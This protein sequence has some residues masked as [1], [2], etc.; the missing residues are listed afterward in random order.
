MLEKSFNIE[1]ISKFIAVFLYSVLIAF[2]ILILQT[3]YFAIFVVVFAPFAFIFLLNKPVTLLSILILIMP[4]SATSLFDMQIMGVPGLKLINILFVMTFFSFIHA[5]RPVDV[6]LN[7]KLFIIGTIALLLIAVIRSVPHIPLFNIIWSEHYSINRYFQSFLLKPIIYLSPFIYLSLFISDRRILRKILRIYIVSMVLLSTFLLG[8]YIF[9]APDKANFESVRESLSVAMHLHGNNLATIYT[10]SFPIF[11]SVFFIRKSILS[12]TGLILVVITIGILYSRTAYFLIVL[13]T[14]L[15]LLISKRPKFI[16]F[17][18]FIGI[19]LSVF[20]PHSI[21][22]RA[23]TGLQSKDR[24]EISAGRIDGIWIPLMQEI[25][26]SPKNVLI[27]RGRHAI[28]FS[29][30]HNSG[31][32]YR[33]GHAHNMYL[34]IL[35]DT[36]LIGLMFFLG[37][38]LFYLRKY[39]IH[40]KKLD[41]LIEDREMLY[42]VIVSIICFLIAGMTGRSFFPTLPNYPIWLALA[43]GSVIIKLNKRTSYGGRDISG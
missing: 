40:V 26:K 22:Q 20:I 27:G 36:G 29:K 1:N 7:E 33:T 28:L 25:S 34:D 30:A 2:A 14:V 21:T 39:L 15:Y 13:S 38:F 8:L 19:L 32:I 35:L 43:I 31:I 18:L 41:L 10:I 5:K 9:N 24:Y 6:Q 12:L 37:F 16:P 17:V 4:F 3:N 11:L 42:G 23:I